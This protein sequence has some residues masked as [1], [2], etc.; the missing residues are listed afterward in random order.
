MKYPL[1]QTMGITQSEAIPIIIS[2]IK[3]LGEKNK[4]LAQS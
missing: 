2:T 1:K 4:L 3:R